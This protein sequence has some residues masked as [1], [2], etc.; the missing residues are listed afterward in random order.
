[1]TLNDTEENDIS[2]IEIHIEDEDNSG[3]V[4]LTIEDAPVRDQAG[5]SQGRGS[6]FT[7]LDAEA[8][9]LLRDILDTRRPGTYD[10]GPLDVN[11]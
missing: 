3:E 11:G 4:W 8:A 9:D 7:I 10:F 6:V 5:D 2:R 1:M